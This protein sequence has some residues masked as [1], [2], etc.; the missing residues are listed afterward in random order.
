MTRVGSRRRASRHER[1]ALAVA[2]LGTAAF[3]AALATGADATGLLAGW[4]GTGATCD[5]TPPERERLP[6]LAPSCDGDALLAAAA[7]LATCAT[8][9]VVDAAA[10]RDETLRRLESD[11]LR[12]HV[13]ELPTVA[14]SF[15]ELDVR[16]LEQLDPEPLLELLSPERQQA[17]EDEQAAQQLALVTE[18]ERRKREVPRDSQVVEIARP[19]VELAPEVARFV[20]E[21]DQRVERQTVA[22]GSN[23]EDLVARSK[24]AELEVKEAPREA[25]TP[26]VREPSQVGQDREAPPTPGLLRM[27]SPGAPDP[28]Q[29][30][31]EAHQRGVRRRRRPGGRRRPRRP[32]RRRRRHQEAPRLEQPAG[33]GGGG[34]GSPRPLVLRASEEVLERVAGGGSVDHLDDVDEGDETA[35][36]T[37]QWVFASFFNRMKRRVHQTWDPVSVWRRHDP[38]GQVYGFKTRVTRVRVTL[39]PGGELK[40]IIVAQPSGVDLLD[41]EAVRAFRAAQPFPNPPAGLVDASGQITFEFGF[42]LQVGGGRKAEWKIFRA[43]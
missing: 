18:A 8:P 23:R 33:E 26:E 27:R 12:C 15:E 4:S 1:A 7:R 31:Q 17:F 34:G 37:R 19:A 24:P 10:C 13:D 42:H 3:H 22:R 41:D 39:G 14:F 11:R 21:Y 38:T 2:L 30:P 43:L 28:A 16:D 9:L 32:S 40:Q 20:S 6:P 25:S 5:A 29:A 36:N 35:L